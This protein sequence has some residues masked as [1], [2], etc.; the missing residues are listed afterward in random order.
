MLVLQAC[1]LH[2]HA[3]GHVFAI[4][5]SAYLQWVLAMFVA[6]LQGRNAVDKFAPRP[7]G[8]EGQATITGHPSLATSAN[9]ERQGA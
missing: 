5:T 3:D 6:E 7:M 9:E 1:V 4:D 8:P 2:C